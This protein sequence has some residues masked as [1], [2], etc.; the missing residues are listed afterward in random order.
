[1]KRLYGTE[2]MGETAENLASRYKI[3]REAQDQFAHHSQMKATKSMDNGRFDKEIMPVELHSK[4][5]TVMFANDEFIKPTT[6]LEILAK[7]KP[8]F[9]KAEDGGTVTAC[10]REA[11]SE[12]E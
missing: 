6:T 9:K 10:S 7:L 1:M 12:A 8:A 5:A 2:A 3:S 4:N 11:N